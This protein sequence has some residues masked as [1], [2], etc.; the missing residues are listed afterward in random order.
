[1]RTHAL[2][3]G[4]DLGSSP[5]PSIGHVAMMSERRTFGSGEDVTR[6]TISSRHYIKTCTIG[7]WLCAWSC[8]PDLLLALVNCAPR[9]VRTAGAK[10][11]SC[12]GKS[13]N[14]ASALCDTDASECGPL[15]AAVCTQQCARRRHV[16]RKNDSSWA[17]PV[18]EHISCTRVHVLAERQHLRLLATLGSHASAQD[19][20]SRGQ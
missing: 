7:T 2:D 11:T 10:P 16:R 15:G 13:M 18:V 9:R 3:F 14:V 5:V 20:G 1:M 17:S 12:C 6:V 19:A 8:I 4:V